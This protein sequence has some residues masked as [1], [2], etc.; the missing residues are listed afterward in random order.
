MKTILIF[1]LSTLCIISYC[2][3]TTYLDKNLNP[4]DKRL[5][6]YFRVTYKGTKVYNRVIDETFY[7]SGNRKSVDCYHYDPMSKTKGKISDGIQKTWYSNGQLKASVTYKE[8]KLNDT[9]FTYWDNGILKRRDIYQDAKLIDGQCFDV[10]GKPIP[11]FD[12]EIFPQYPGGDSGLLETI[13]NNIRMPESL[14]V[15]GI[16]YVR[17]IAIFFVNEGGYVT[18]ISIIEGYNKE[19]NDE[20]VRVISKLKKWSPGLQDG[21]PVKVPYSVPVTFQIK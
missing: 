5:A 12:Y 3:D 9:L 4:V 6:E 14:K 18:D 11:Y 2:Q 21:E 15:N 8:G 10:A 19:V 7:I 13:Y 17:V 20:V 1:V 16:P